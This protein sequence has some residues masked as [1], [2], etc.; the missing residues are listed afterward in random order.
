M[1]NPP[2]VDAQEIVQSRKYWINI[3][4]IGKRTLKLPQTGRFGAFIAHQAMQ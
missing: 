4:K 3:S 2:T 1:A